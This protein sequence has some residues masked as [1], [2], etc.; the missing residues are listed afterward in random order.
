MKCFNTNMF[1]MRML[2]WAVVA[3]CSGLLMTGCAR[4]KDLYSPEEGSIYM[5]QAYQDRSVMT[6]YK[7]DS[8]Q[9][10]TFGA[11]Y[12]GFNGPNSDITVKF[13]VVP[14]LVDQYNITNAYLGYTY[15]PL[16]DS[17]YTL[18]STTG[19]IRAGKQSSDPL[20][21]LVSGKKISF[22]YHYLLP[23]RITSVSAGSK[24]SSLSVAYFKLDSLQT[25]VKDLTSSGTL[26]VSDENRDGANAKEGSSKLVDN[27]YSTKF[28]SFNYNPNFWTKLKLNAPQKLDAYELTSG[29]DAPERDPRNWLF[30][31]S[32]N[33]TDWTTLDTRTGEIF[34]GR[35]LTRRFN[36]NTSD[37]YSYYR[38]LITANGGASLIQITEWKLV[39]FY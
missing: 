5:P 38:L 33:G 27:D 29:N 9:R 1:F 32:N 26:T 36:L 13:E 22:G 20:F 34:L 11:Y 37:A 12:G 31:G 7:M 25:R 10:V 17:V 14:S 30:Q 2:F 4:S 23:I 35:Q 21:I 18:S 8:I 19:V 6:L 3:G 28:L 24:D 39:Q 16:P 15:Y